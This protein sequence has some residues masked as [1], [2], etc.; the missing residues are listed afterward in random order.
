MAAVMGGCVL[1]L[2]TQWI[3]GVFVTF[4]KVYIAGLSLKLLGKF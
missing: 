2:K 1:L 4:I 3:Y